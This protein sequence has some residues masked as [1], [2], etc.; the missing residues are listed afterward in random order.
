VGTSVNSFYN[1]I[2]SRVT[3]FIKFVCDICVVVEDQLTGSALTFTRIKYMY[4]VWKRVAF[5]L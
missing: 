3:A 4:F 2:I 1:I 5:S